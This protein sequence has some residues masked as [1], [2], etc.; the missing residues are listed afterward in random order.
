MPKKIEISQEIIKR[1]IEMHSQLWGY[2]RIGRELGIDRRKVANIIRDHKKAENLRDIGSVRRDVAGAYF[3]QHIEYLSQLSGQLLGLTL[4]PRLREDLNRLPEDIWFELQKWAEK[5]F[6]PKDYFRSTPSLNDYIVRITAEIKVNSLKSHIPSLS[7]LI[8]EWEL[9]A[10]GYNSKFQ[11]VVP[12]LK[13]LSE[14]QGIQSDLIE[15]GLLTTFKLLSEQVLTLK[16]EL[17]D[18]LLV[19]VKSSNDVAHR[20]SQSGEAR[21]LLKSLLPHL[22]E[23]ERC[24]KKIA[25]VLSPDRLPMELMLEECEICA[26]SILPD[27]RVS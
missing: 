5:F 23:L 16:D 25:S 3:K 22:V 6:V 12:K 27:T 19:D 20:L 26:I 11:D 10:K 4:P 2:S 24:F 17:A 1:C 15:P 21:Q 14:S 18:H 13:K 9:A 8:K 7:R